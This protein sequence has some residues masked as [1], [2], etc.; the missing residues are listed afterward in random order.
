MRAWFVL[1]L[2]LIAAGAGVFLYKV[3]GLN[4]PLSTAERPDVWRVEETFEVSGDGGRVVVDVPIPRSSPYHRLISEEVRSGLLRFSIDQTAG[5][6]RGHWSGKLD[7]TTT[8]SYGVTLAAL[9]YERTLPDRDTTTSYGKSV[10]LFLQPSAH[11]PSDEPALRELSQ[12]LNLD[13]TNKARAAR[14]IFTFVTQE[15]GALRSERETDVATVIRTGR[16]TPLGRA[17]L[18]CA[19]MRLN[20]VP[21]RIVTG[22]RLV[23]SRRAAPPQYWNEVHVGAGWVPLDA[24]NGL[25]GRLPADR[26]A[27]ST[28]DAELLHVTGATEFTHRFL[29]E[30]EIESYAAFIRRRIAGSPHAIDRLSPLLLPVET[31]RGLRFLLLVPLGALAMVVVRNVIGVR[32]FGMFMPMLI[33]LAMSSTGLLWGTA[34]LGLII[35]TA[36]LSRLFIQRLYLLLAARIAFVLTVVVLLMLVVVTVGNRFDLPSAGVEAFPFVIMTMIVE[37]ISVSLEEEGVRN[38]LNRVAST[39][40]AIYLTYAVVQARGLQ[41]FFLVFPEVL[42]VILGLLVAVGRYT[43]YR[44]V[45]LIRFRELLAAQAGRP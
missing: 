4:Y 11:V 24:E 8:L 17:R 6:R 38:T 39:L 14:E 5:D 37:R 18:L 29:L 45:E 10:A 12:E 15:V 22:L 13:R 21:C 28:S 1:S 19:L 27:L 30:A 42:L 9:S 3:I 7:G 23:E 41:A 32:T 44:L 25:V 36:L 35:T 33:A 43:G 40:F 31:Q 34:F 20:G 26:V 2:V 16:G